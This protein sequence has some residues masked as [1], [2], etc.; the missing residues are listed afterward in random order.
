ME[1]E[2]V[3]MAKAMIQTR[4]KSTRARPCCALTDE[5]LRTRRVNCAMEGMGK[6]I[7]GREGITSGWEV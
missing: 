7:M 4:H 6:L 2:T 3:A 5:F 1:T